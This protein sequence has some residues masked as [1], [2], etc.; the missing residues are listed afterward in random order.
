MLSFF[1]CFP[2]SQLGF[3]VFVTPKFVF[4]FVFAPGMAHTDL[5]VGWL[6]ILSPGTH[7]LRDYHQD[8]AS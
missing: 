1:E 2:Q 4:L 5:L 8:S 3:L 7:E 6:E